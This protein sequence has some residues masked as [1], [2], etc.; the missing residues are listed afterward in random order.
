[1]NIPVVE[2]MIKA[3]VVLAL[4]A[5][6]DLLLRRRASAAA[7]HFAWTVTTAALLV[8]PLASLSLPAWSVRVPVSAPAANEAPRA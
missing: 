6:A 2:I 3:S 5:V 8:L 4:A 1:M 7:R